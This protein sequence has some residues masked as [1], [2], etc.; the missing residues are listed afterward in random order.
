MILL[1]SA[2][3]ASLTGVVR[4]VDG[5]ALEGVV[6]TAYDERL[7][8]ASTLTDEEGQWSLEGLPAGRYRV[9]AVALGQPYADRFIPGVWD[10][11]TAEVLPLSEDE[12]LAGLDFALPP[13]GS[14]TGVVVD[15]LGQ[16]LA[17]VEL[18]CEGADGRTGLIQRGA[19]SDE[20]GAFTCVGL[21]ASA[22]GSLY[23]VSAELPGWPD[24]YLGGVYRDSDG[25]EEVQVQLQQVSDIG[26]FMLMDGIQVS[27]TVLSDGEPVS[28]AFVHVYSYGQVAD[29]V[30]DE[31][32]AYTAD[33][34]P[35]G[36]IVAWASLDGYGLTYHPDNGVPKTVLAVEEGEHAQGVD[37]LLPVEAALTGRIHGEGDLSGVTL[38][39]YNETYTVALGAAVEA[40]G[41]FFAGRLRE[42]TWRLYFYASDEG[43]LDDFAR[44]ADGQ[45]LEWDLQEGEVLEVDLDLRL[46]AVL[47]GVVRDDHGDPV[48]GAVVRA[49]PADS[50]EYSA[51]SVRSERDGRYRLDGLVPGEQRIDIRY[52]PYCAQDPGYVPWYSGD[53]PHELAT[54]PLDIE[55]GEQRA[56]DW[57]LPWDGE[58]DGMSD[59]WEEEVGLDPSRDD[60]AEDP[61]QDGL[62][63][64]Q[65]YWLGTDPL[66]VEESGRCGGC[67]GGAGGFWLMGLLLLRRRD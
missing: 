17:D 20:Q 42:G 66:D 1:G 23:A 51:R 9:R 41:S 19:V 56:M 53:T 7:A 5:G 39:A 61:D 22:Q 60:S 50:D 55:E 52:T 36:D 65:E 57:E 40:D 47:E 34:L 21:D 6:V 32:G 46:G 58:H 38:L 24:Q 54:A 2:L 26:D 35:S 12:E 43:Y 16:P 62:S 10:F 67:G 4:D 31:Q 13:A 3:A 45:R 63:N 44:D 37:I 25:V 48:Y 49:T 59:A 18:T 28:G 11:C 30:S 27:G 15:T 14:L 64:L 33:G 29:T 8:Y